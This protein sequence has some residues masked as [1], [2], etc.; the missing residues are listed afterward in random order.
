MYLIGKKTLVYFNYN[1]VIHIIGNVNKQNLNV[2]VYINR[3]LTNKFFNSNVTNQFY[4]H[5]SALFNGFNFDCAFY[6][7]LYLL[8]F[9]AYKL[10]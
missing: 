4:T 1:I 5:C 2:Y 3:R 7:I 9:K 8:C 10:D 6:L